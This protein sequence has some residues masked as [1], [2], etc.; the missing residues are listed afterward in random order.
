MLAIWG[1]GPLFSGY[2]REYHLRGTIL[3]GEFWTLV[4]VFIFCSKLY[5]LLVGVSFY[6]SFYTGKASHL[7]HFIGVA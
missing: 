1:R 2:L 4:D 7:D 6:G 5:W 3:L